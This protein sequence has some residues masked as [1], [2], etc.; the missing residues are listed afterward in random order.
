MNESVI[1]AGP[2]DEWSD[3]NFD[4]LGQ[5]ATRAHPLLNIADD[6]EAQIRELPI[7]WTAE[8]IQEAR[9]VHHLL[10]IAGITQRNP[11]P[12]RHGRY[13]NV[14]ARTYLA[15]RALGELQDRI[16]RISRWHHRETGDGGT[17]GDFCVECE[18]RWP[19]DTRKMA[20]G[21]YADEPRGGAMSFDG[22]DGW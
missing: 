1:P 19:C 2:A 11:D 22:Q 6:H 16:A 13:L 8:V 10:D 14:D 20:D 15:I 3:V 7:A 5:L 18:R 9:T 4:L 12:D 21:T 17:V